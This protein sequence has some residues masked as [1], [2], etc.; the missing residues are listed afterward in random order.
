VKGV[1]PV[2]V[3]PNV[4]MVAKGETSLLSMLNTALGEAAN[5]GTIDQIVKKSAVSPGLFL[6]RQKP[7][8]TTP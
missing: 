7:Y 3:F 6:L 4:M 1:E 2:R 5:T 8:R